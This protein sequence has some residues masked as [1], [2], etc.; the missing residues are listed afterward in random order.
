ML[1]TDTV[2][3][4]PDTE[5]VRASWRRQAPVPAVPAAP[6]AVV[7]LTSARALSVVRR[8]V[9]DLLTDSL[10][11][12]GAGPRDAVEDVVERAVL[13]IDEMTSN[14][15]RHG[16]PPARLEVS[17]AGDRWLVEVVDAAPGRLPAP[18]V[19][20]PAGAGGYGLYVI[21]DL[22]LGHGVDVRDDHKRV[23]A[24]LGKHVPPS[25]PQ[26]PPTPVPDPRPARDPA[27]LYARLFAA[28]PTP[29]LAVTPGMVVVDASDAYLEMVG[30]RRDDVVGR[31]IVD[32]FP[33][34]PESLDVDGT[35][36]VLKSFLRAAATRRP[37]PMPVARYDV[38]D[39]SGTPVERYWSHVAFPVLADDDEVL[40]VVQVLTEVTGYVLGERSP[41]PADGGWRSRAEQVEALLL[42][43][44]GEVRA[45]Q[46]AEREALALRAALAEA[47]LGMAGSRDAAE[48]ERVLVERGRAT[49]GATVGAVSLRVGEVLRQNITPGA[50]A[51]IA[52]YSEIPLDSPLHSAVVARQGRPV[53]LPDPQAC[54]A[55]APEMA[56]V[57]QS[58]GVRALVGF[59]LRVG[60][61]LRGSLS[62][63]WD[64]P[65]SFTATDVDVLTSLAA[66]YGQALARIEAREAE[67][68]QTVQAV[69][70]SRALQRSLLSEPARL[71][72]VD[73][74]ARYR[75]AA[76]LA[77]V[78][79]DWFDSFPAS[80]RR[81]N[82][83]V[84][85]V[86]GHDQ[87]AAAQ[88]GQTR[89]LLRGI[90]STLGGPP[91][92]V[93][94]S[95]DR[96]LR[97][98][99]T[100]VYATLVL[101]T[102]GRGDD[103]AVTVRW[104]NAGHPAPLVV[105]ADGRV[106]TLQTR[107]EPMLGVDADR[108][109]CDHLARLAP[110]ETLLLYTDGLVERRRADLD[111]GE[112]WLRDTVA[113]AAP[114]RGAAELCDHLLDLVAGHAEDDVVLLALSVTP[115]G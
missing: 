14:A 70:M 15:V 6:A 28:L 105:R 52:R 69:Q 33:P 60:G 101:A 110:G 67:L 24:V 62:F 64:R 98:L 100:G 51:A 99:D 27:D 2:G 92:A 18:A 7:E 12:T 115:P 45:A 25:E 84:G 83:V 102:V 71:P 49:V 89:N 107:P 63:G 108:A 57:L 40:L 53:L 76:Q 75:P 96:V 80:D 38:A 37:D 68:R 13:V 50:D 79:G 22:T 61:Q 58:T 113:D 86:T 11:A 17:D 48:L 87:D 73:V 16:T 74:V 109:R 44:A 36:V 10:L 29:H 32:L 104:T 43:R 111:A 21:A 30:L 39:A 34:G 56:E 55:F 8:R 103:G 93:V 1:V 54:T 47:A 5:T 90:A 77:Q 19:D 91:A 85:D 41:D 66:Q 94:R 46:A 3:D 106:E 42:E 59:P 82:V 20:R 9:R 23:W 95:L 78:G 26:T 35:P 114:G 65:R 72:G 31:S 88:M 97:D 4:V 81:L 112:Q